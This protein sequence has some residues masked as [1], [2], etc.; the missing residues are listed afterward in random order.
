MPKTKHPAGVFLLLAVLLANQVCLASN[1]Y[2]PHGVGSKNKSLAGAGMAMPEEAISMVNNPAVAVLLGNRLEAGLTAF[3]P[4][5]NYTTFESESGGEQGVFTIGPADID[6]SKELFLMPEFAGIKQLQN[7]TALGTAFYMRSG[8]STAYKGG[9]AAFDPDGSGPLDVTS[10]PGTFGD[11]DIRFE[12]SQAYVDIAWAKKLSED[13]SFGI[14]VV[15]AT[16]SLEVGGLRGLSQYSEV[17]AA[18]G[19]AQTPSALSGNGTD[20]SYGVGLKVG[21]HHEFADKFSFGLMYQS[22]ISMGAHDDY[23]DLLA[24]AGKLDIPPW[25]RMGASWQALPQLTVSIDAQQMWFSKI[26]AL[27]NSFGNLDHC[28]SAQ[29]GGVEPGSCLGGANGAGFGWADV[30]VYSLGLSWLVNDNWTLRA[31]ISNSEQPVPREETT[32]NL[33][34]PSMSEVH[35]TSGVTWRMGNDRELSFAFM[36]TEEESLH[37]AGQLD[38]GQEVVITTDQFDLQLSY[39]WTY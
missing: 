11:G 19:G 6:S 7:D 26:D 23:S 20:R 37:H 35:F 25:V 22:K 18:S 21:F 8:M 12:L 14:S 5:R 17:F 38:P 10:L 2:F 28:P 15:L 31:G 32:L 9:V 34:F 36:Y 24:D 3:M 13:T 27:A 33:L 30:P 1:G 16:Q 39:S 29:R 4:R